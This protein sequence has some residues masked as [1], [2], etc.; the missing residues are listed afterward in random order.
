MF[1]TIN[2]IK[3]IAQEM[4]LKLG[5]DYPNFSMSFFRRRLNY[6]FEQMSV[7][8]IQDFN[9]MLASIVKVDEIAYYMAVPCTEMFRDPAFWRTL[10]KYISGR[11]NIRIWIP[12]LTNCYE[13]FS[14]VIILKQVGVA[15]YKIVANCISEKTEKE[16]KTLKI[17]S[18]DDV[19]N[20]S[21]FERLENQNDSYANYVEEH[22]DGK[23]Y[24]KGEL[25]RNVEFRVGWFMNREVEVYDLVMVRNVLVD[26]SMSLYERAAQR[27]CQSVGE[28][29]L[30]T[31]GVRERFVIKIP[32]I[33]IVDD[34]EG[35]YGKNFKTV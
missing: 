9:S 10:K 34:S 5:I 30:L 22:E 12:N 29:G 24:F 27:L 11:E 20:K 16:I 32:S 1:L 4:K 25:L 15:N 14:L 26:Y 19:V 6:V 7:H 2:D 28:G 35:I 31:L 8:R 18:K 33:S 23:S 17:P 13:L 21:N 3:T